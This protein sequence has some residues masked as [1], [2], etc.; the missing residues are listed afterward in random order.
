MGVGRMRR[1]AGSI[2]RLL[3]LA[4]VVAI[5]WSVPDLPLSAPANLL[6][7]WGSPLLAYPVVWAGRLVVD[8]TPTASGVRTVTAAV[9]AGVALSLGA[10]LVRAIT[11][12]ADWPGVVLAMPRPLGAV[13]AAVTGLAAT[14]TVATLALRG[15]GAPFFIKLSSRLATDW[16]YRWTRNPMV[17]ATICWLACMG[18]W[19]QSLLFVVW[20]LADVTPALLFFVRHF[21]EREL[22]LRFGESYR[23]Y[24]RSTPFLI[25]RRP[26]AR[27]R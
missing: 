23:D 25:P 27:G 19:F 20:V 11:T 24:R 10:P 18:L 15:L 1:Y 5:L 2:A 9:Q 26:P 7:I 12:Q 6:L 17:L 21:E 3:L 22:E 8:R 14:A 4:V 13:L 16:L